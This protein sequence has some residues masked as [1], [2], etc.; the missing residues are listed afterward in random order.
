MRV[1]SY[2]HVHVWALYACVYVCIYGCMYVC[3]CT[4][5]YVVHGHTVGYCASPL[6]QTQANDLVGR[7]MKCTPHYI[8]CLKPNET[9]KPHDWE[10]DRSTCTLMCFLFLGVDEDCYSNY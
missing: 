6:L 8:R 3:I 10:N 5:M 4:C 9:K 1:C 2:M 7:L